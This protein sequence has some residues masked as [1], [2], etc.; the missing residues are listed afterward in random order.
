MGELVNFIIL[1]IDVAKHFGSIVRVYTSHDD[2]HRLTPAQICPPAA[3]EG[4]DA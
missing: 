1:I 2:D 4:E 3:E